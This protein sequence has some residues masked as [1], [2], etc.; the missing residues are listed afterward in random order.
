MRVDDLDSCRN[1]AGASE[2]IID[3]L[4]IYGLHWD[5]PVCYQSHHSAS[6]ASVISKLLIEDLVFPCT[7]TRKKLAFYHSSVYPGICLKTRQNTDQPHSLRIKSKNITLDFKDELQ[8]VISEQLSQSHGDFIVK[9]KE[10]ILAYQLAVV[11][12][13]A[14]QNITHVVRGF[15]L[16]ESTIKQIYLQQVLGYSTPLYCHV[17]II[18]NQQG[19]K[20]SKQAFAE[21]VSTDT[22]NKTLFLLLELLQ[23]NPPNILKYASTQDILDWAIEHW[24]PK[25]L[26]KIRAINNG[27]D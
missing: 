23:Q 18:V 14:L 26:K 20:L 17:P 9:R 4:Q 24:N 5:G 21:A 15:D 1:V 6:Y 25:H 27:I 10:N 2:Q 12:D 8:G 16:L 22:V 11:I 3:T 19:E 13:D 7:C